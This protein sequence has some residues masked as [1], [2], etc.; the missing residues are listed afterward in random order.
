MFVNVVVCITLIPHH[1]CVLHTVLSIDLLNI[2][3][4]AF[5]PFR[6]TGSLLS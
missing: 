3:I 2:V 6:I 5:I 1:L 4:G